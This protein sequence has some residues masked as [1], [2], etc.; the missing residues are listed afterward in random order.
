M[1]A[2]CNKQKSLQE[3]LQEEKRAIN[4]YINI[5]NLVI[6]DEYPKDGKFNEKE[7]YKIQN[8]LGVMYMHVVDSGNG[9]RPASLVDEVT[10]RF[11]YRHDIAVSDS[12]ILTWSSSGFVYPY[13]FKYGLSQSYSATNSMLCVGWVVPLTYVGEHAVVDLIIP[14]ALGSYSD[15]SNINPVFYKGVTYTNFY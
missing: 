12:S 4:R 15:N 6:L 5:N 2:S 10:V 8:E 13:S 9:Q 11:E 14:S 1:F 3:R 7:F